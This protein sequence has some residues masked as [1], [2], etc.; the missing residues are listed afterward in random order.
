MLNCVNKLEF[1]LCFSMKEDETAMNSKY[2]AATPHYL[3]S[4]GDYEF[5]SGDYYLSQPTIK[6]LFDTNQFQ[7]ILLV[8]SDSENS[9]YDEIKNN[10]RT[11]IYYSFG[12]KVKQTPLLQYLFPVGLGP[13]SKI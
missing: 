4:W 12:L 6:P 2:I 5:K 9:F 3:E 13:S 7:D 11:N 1:S 8:L 10:W